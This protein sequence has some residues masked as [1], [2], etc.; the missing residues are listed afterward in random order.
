MQEEQDTAGDG[1]LQRRAMC[2][3]NLEV[4]GGGFPQPDVHSLLVIPVI[5]GNHRPDDTR[6]YNQ[7]TRGPD[8]SVA[9]FRPGITRRKF[10]PFGNAGANCPAFRGKKGWSP[11]PY[12]V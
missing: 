5:V 11:H 10:D 9:V 1:V 2:L 7:V 3:R 8:C 6:P 12:G 4:G